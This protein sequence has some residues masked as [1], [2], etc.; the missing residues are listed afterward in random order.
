M[1]LFFFAFLVT[2]DTTLRLSTPG[3]ENF[4]G[5]LTSQFRDSCLLT[6]PL[7]ALNIWLCLMAPL[8]TPGR[9]L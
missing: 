8:I 7:R 1:L 5:Q 6:N 4:A 2:V 9:V 3:Y